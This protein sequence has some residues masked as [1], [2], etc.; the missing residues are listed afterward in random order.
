MR[1]THYGQTFQLQSATSAS[2]YFSGTNEQP[3]I[4]QATQ[5]GDVH[6]FLRSLA[7]QRKETVVEVYVNNVLRQTIEISDRISSDYFIEGQRVSIGR[8]VELFNLKPDDVIKI[9]TPETD[10]I[11][12]R[13]FI[14][15]Q[16]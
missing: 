8:R 12:C 11:I 6:F 13:M 10:E 3:I 15:T 14:T 2:E 4:Y 7:H 5:A 1:P 9:I 16:G